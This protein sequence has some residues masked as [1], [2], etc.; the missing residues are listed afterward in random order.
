M[1]CPSGSKAQGPRTHSQARLRRLSR[2]YRATS[3][4][5]TVS[6]EIL[7]LKPC[8]KVTAEG[9]AAGRWKSD[10]VVSVASWSPRRRGADQGPAPP[11][12]RTGAQR[13]ADD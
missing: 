1:C 3:V 5:G 9:P 2:Y 12:T 8:P 7:T 11:H 10:E 6:P 13:P 4:D